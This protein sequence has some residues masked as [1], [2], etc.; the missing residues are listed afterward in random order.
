[1]GKDRGPSVTKLFKARMK[2]EGRWREWQD[3]ILA[4]RK[5]KG[6]NLAAATWETMRR[7]GYEGSEKER[8]LAEEYHLRSLG[9]TIN[10]EREAI[11][12]ERLTEDFDEAMRMLPDTALGSTEID[13]I[14]GHPLMCK[15]DRQEGNLKK[16]IVNATDILQAPNGRAPSKS[17]VVQLQ[18]WC[19]APREFF[20]QVL[21]EQKKQTEEAEAQKIEADPGIDEIERLL[22]EVKS[23]QNRATPT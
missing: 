2:R 21:S 5:E 14:R 23:G 7:M 3:T 18:H 9:V 16:I 1:M 15:A 8:E 17:A 10:K 4:V 11:N 20:K 12:R 13:W 6:T 22:K 19:N